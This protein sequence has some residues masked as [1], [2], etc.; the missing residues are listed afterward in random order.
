[1]PGPLRESHKIVKKDLLENAAGP[2]LE[3]PGAQT[4]R[5]PVQSK[6]TWTS[7]KSHF[8]RK[9]T[10]KCRAPEVRRTVCVSLR[11]RNAQGH[12]TRAILTENLLEKCR[13]PDGA[14]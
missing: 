14:P 1:M 11:S 9:F 13:K 8:T 10:G 5:E 3:N 7:Q 6:C 2:E 12:V 4:L